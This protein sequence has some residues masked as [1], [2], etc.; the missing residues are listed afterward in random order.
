MGKNYQNK[1]DPRQLFEKFLDPEQAGQAAQDLRTGEQILVRY[2]AP[3]PDNRTI[4]GIKLKISGALLR[5]RANKHKQIGYKAV[6]AAAAVIIVAALTITLVEKAAVESE[7][8]AYSSKIAK[9]IWDSDNVADDDADLALLTAEIE[10]IESQH[11]ALQLSENGGN[12]HTEVAELETELIEI[13]SDFW[14]G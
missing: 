6:V 2:P 5:K 12:G 1:E 4:A 8:A 7:T 14:K 11:L 9:V 13:N 3:A 10:Q